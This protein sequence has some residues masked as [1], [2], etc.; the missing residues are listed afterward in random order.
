MIKKLKIPKKLPNNGSD[1]VRHVASYNGKIPVAKVKIGTLQNNRKGK[2]STSRALLEEMYARAGGNTDIFDQI[3]RSERFEDNLYGIYEQDSR[4]FYLDYN[5]DDN[6]SV[7]RAY[8][9][10]TVLSE[11]DH[12]DDDSYFRAI[13]N[14]QD[15][16]LGTIPRNL[17][18]KVDGYR[19]NFERLMGVMKSLK[20]VED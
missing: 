15:A 17:A 6:A 8:F 19:E 10:A 20:Y 1:I 14:L 2:E 3:I 4:H 11:S 5:P 9:D 7:R 18:E 13:M 16:G 12:I